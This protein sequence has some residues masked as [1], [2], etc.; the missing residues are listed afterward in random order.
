MKMMTG[1]RNSNYFEIKVAHYSSSTTDKWTPSI[2]WFLANVI[3]YFLHKLHSIKWHGEIIIIRIFGQRS[4]WY[5]WKYNPGNILQELSITTGASVS[6]AAKIKSR[7]HCI[8]MSSLK[9]CCEWLAILICT[10]TVC[11]ISTA[12]CCLWG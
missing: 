6:R 7:C 3:Q 11:M 9:V 2:Q 12:K 1:R 5:I 8:Q 4:L 10:P